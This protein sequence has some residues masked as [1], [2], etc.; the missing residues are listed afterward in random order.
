LSR[1]LANQ[2]LLTFLAEPQK[3]AGREPVRIMSEIHSIDFV[4][5]ERVCV[6]ASTER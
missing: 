4:H 6:P 3:K 5:A 2:F 1:Q